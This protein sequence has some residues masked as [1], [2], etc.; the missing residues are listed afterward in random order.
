MGIGEID[1]R[2]V[3]KLA[4]GLGTG[5]IDTRPDVQWF[6]RDRLRGM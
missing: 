2:P 1:T 3:P 6:L 4:V 5:E